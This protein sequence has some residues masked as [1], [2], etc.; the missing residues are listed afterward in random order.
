[1]FYSVAETEDHHETVLSFLLA[2]LLCV[3]IM[4]LSVPADETTPAD[5]EAFVTETAEERE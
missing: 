1:L 3:G 4:P 5:E 2:L